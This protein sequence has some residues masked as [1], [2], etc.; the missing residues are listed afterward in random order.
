MNTSRHV[1]FS[2]YVTI[3]EYSPEI[4][5]YFSP[6]HHMRRALHNEHRRLVAELKAKEDEDARHKAKEDE[7]ARRKAKAAQWKAR[8]PNRDDSDDDYVGGL[9]KEERNLDWREQAY[10]RWTRGIQY[11]D[12]EDDINEL[13]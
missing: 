10:L 12:L 3:E 9:N 13:D 2:S 11:D 4:M 8:Q 6:T 5:A 7:D 1:G